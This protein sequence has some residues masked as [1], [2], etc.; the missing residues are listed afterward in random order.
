MQ[1]TDSRSCEGYLLIWKIT[2]TIT[3]LRFTTCPVCECCLPFLPISVCLSVLHL[4]LPVSSSSTLIHS[5][6][7]FSLPPQILSSLSF[8]LSIACH[9]SLSLILNPFADPH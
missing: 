9:I 6:S 8:S 5:F 3:K 7:L 4:L 2:V 1:G